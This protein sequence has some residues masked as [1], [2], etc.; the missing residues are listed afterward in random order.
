MG[1]WIGGSALVCQYRGG[2][3]VCTGSVEIGE[4]G[5][6]VGALRTGGKNDGDSDRFAPFICGLF[7]M[8]RK[9]CQIAPYAIGLSGGDGLRGPGG[10]IRLCGGH[11]TGER[12]ISERYTCE[13]YIGERYTGDER[14]GFA[15]E[16]NPQKN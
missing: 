9:N 13:R 16:P 3:S 12:Y 8:A 6:K 2:E 14:E 1:S 5:G 10:T 15:H 7:Q 11:A 4:V